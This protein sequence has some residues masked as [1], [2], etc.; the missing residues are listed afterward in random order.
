MKKRKLN[1]AT[2]STCY[3]SKIV[4][5]KKTF[6][7]CS[8]IHGGLSLRPDPVIE[9]MVDTLNSKF[10]TKQVS[11]IILNSKSKRPNSLKSEIGI[12]WLKFFSK[13]QENKL[14]SLNTYYSH[15]LLGKRKNLNL[16][17]ANKQAKF[18]G[19]SVPN[20]IS[21]EE[22]AQVF[23]TID[24]G[25]VKN[26]SDL[27]SDYKNNPVVYR[28]PVEFIFRLAEFY[29]FV[30]EGRLDKLKSFE[31]FP[32]KEASSFLFAIAVGDDGAQGIGMPDLIS[33]INI[34]ERIANS[35]EQFLL[36]GADVDQNS[37]IVTIYF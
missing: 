18:Q 28:E 7:A 9:G 27:C 5:W 15:D 37:G 29:L 10:R 36:F 13:S 3:R 16:R 34:G 31:H 4:R 25:T 19:N 6:D 17:K 8:V 14:R 11:N 22:L 30:N 2:K 33:F 24:I 1:P 23:N 20:Y 35:A 21:Y 26:L 12:N 32:C